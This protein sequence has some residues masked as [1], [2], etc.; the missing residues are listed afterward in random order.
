VL[1]VVRGASACFFI[2]R[3][4]VMS[5]NRDYVIA[6]FRKTMIGSKSFK[7]NVRASDGETK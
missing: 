2:L 3:I 5:K 7:R 6:A 1:F 4:L